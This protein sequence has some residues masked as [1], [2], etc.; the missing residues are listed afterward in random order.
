MSP[1]EVVNSIIA[2]VAILVSLVAL[3]RTRKIAK[4]QIELEVTHANLNALSALVS[5]YTEQAKLYERLLEDGSCY[6]LGLDEGNLATIIED[7]YARR[8][9]TITEIE[10]ILHACKPQK[11]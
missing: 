10:K 2:L 7:Y 5:G 4:K 9:E 11:T 3:V 8:H 6:E 1:Y